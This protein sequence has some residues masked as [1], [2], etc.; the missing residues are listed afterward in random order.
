MLMHTMNSNGDGDISDADDASVDNNNNN[1]DS[2]NDEVC[3]R[4]MYTY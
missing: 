3:T 4:Y 1:D 2:N